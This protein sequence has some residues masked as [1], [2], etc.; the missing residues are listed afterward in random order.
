MAEPPLD[1][2]G[3]VALVGERVAAGMTQRVRV[4]REFKAAGS[5]RPLDHSSKAGGRKRGSALTD[6]DEGR[7]RAL[8]LEPA[9]G[10]HCAHCL[11]ASVGVVG[12]DIAA[13]LPVTRDLYLL[14]DDEV[15]EVRPGPVSAAPGVT[16]S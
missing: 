10:P 4:R 3:V 16:A 7:R 2:P 15:A 8:P 12:S 11:T 13:L 9:Q 5:G 6:E 14:G 1:C